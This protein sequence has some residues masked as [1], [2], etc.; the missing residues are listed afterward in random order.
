MKKIVSIAGVVVVFLLLLLLL[1]PAVVDAEKFRP[2][3]QSTM[4]QALKRKVAF[5]QIQLSLLPSPSITL[6]NFRLQDSRLPAG[7][8]FLTSRSVKMSVDPISYF[9]RETPEIRSI[10]IAEPV[11]QLN[12][13]MLQPSRESAGP[14]GGTERENARQALKNMV[15][16]LD[17]MTV[18]FWENGSEKQPAMT[19]KN[20]RARFWDPNPP[21]GNPFEMPQA[22]MDLAGSTITS[23]YV[24]VP[25]EVENGTVQLIQ[26]RLLLD[27]FRGRL[28]DSSLEGKIQVESLLEPV[29]HFQLTCPDL[30]VESLERWK[31]VGI[32]QLSSVNATGISAASGSTLA[33]EVRST[34]D[35]TLGVERLWIGPRQ[36]QKV[37]MQLRWTEGQLAID[38]MQGQMYGGSLISSGQIGFETA[39][40]TYQLKTEIR[41]ALLQQILPPGSDKKSSMEGK[42]DLDA[43]L[44]GS[45]LNFH[46]EK[47][48]QDLRASG[49]FTVREG[50]INT[51]DISEKLKVL[52]TL[53]KLASGDSGIS[54]QIQIQ[55]DFQFDGKEVRSRAME[56]RAGLLTLFLDGSFTPKGYLDYQVEHKL[57][58]PARG[59]DGLFGAIVG[60]V[61][62]A[63]QS[64]GPFRIRGTLEDLEVIF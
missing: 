51:F 4:E 44:N 22:E 55:S 32:S 62:S 2:I 36:A 16:Q 26:N 50:K 29:V 35:G 47:T 25:M 13:A 21:E 57:Q 37:V 12:A 60:V 30:K 64:T 56:V 14:A 20:M 39:I 8:D 17:G 46:K 1:I 23:S 59:S 31:T 52:N 49:K 15:L 34:I 18:K 5:D 42:L 63:T 3:I 11:V 6:N 27:H 53:A 24:S 9:T 28:E 7:I 33:K 48:M 19:V 40:P 43:V 58:Q 61:S 41:E 54:S 45:G 10:E 38:R